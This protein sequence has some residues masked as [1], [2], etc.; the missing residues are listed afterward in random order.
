MSP[1][2]SS[3]LIAFRVGDIWLGIAPEHASTS[4]AMPP[5]APLPDGPDWLLGI[6]WSQGDPIG[7]VDLARLAH[8]GSTE[9]GLILRLAGSAIAFAIEA[10]AHITPTDPADVPAF[11]AWTDPPLQFAGGIVH[12]L[13]LSTVVAQIERGR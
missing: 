13:Q 3:T 11:A 5:C 9:G 10:L 7:V 12:P 4:H 2:V 8:H 1:P 6:A